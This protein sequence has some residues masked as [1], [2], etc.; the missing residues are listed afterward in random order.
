MVPNHYNRKKEFVKGE[1]AGSGGLF[2]P[3]GFSENLA[4]YENFIV[5]GNVLW[6][7]IN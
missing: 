5:N 7:D 6:Y 4:I 2:L 1:V 3:R